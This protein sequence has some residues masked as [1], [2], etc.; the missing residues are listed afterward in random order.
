[1]SVW[2]KF[3]FSACLALG[4]LAV[5]EGVFRLAGYA[6]ALPL[7]SEKPGIQTYFWISDPRLGFR[8][9][10]NGDYVY[11]LI[12][13][14]PRVTTDCFGYRNGYGWFGPTTNPIV[15]FLGDSTVFCAEVDD[16]HTG[17]SE[18]A[19]LLGPGVSV[20]NAGVRG[21]STVQAKRMLEECLAR[22][23]SIKIVV[24]CFCGNDLEENLNSDLYFPARAPVL[25]WNEEKRRFV[26][27]EVTNPV[28]P[29]GN[30]FESWVAGHR[31][32]RRIVLQHKRWDRRFRDRLRERLAFFHALC[33]ATERL[34]DRRGA[35]QASESEVSEESNREAQP[36]EI[37]QVTALKQILTEM[38]GLCRRHDVAF[39]VTR[40]TRQ[41]N[42]AAIRRWCEEAG[43]RFVSASTYIPANDL[44]YRARTR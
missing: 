8:N 15:L 22:H 17:P 41:G 9:R 18:V 29:W 28:V 36:E 14:N 27:L 2:K 24:Y 34:R 11:D 32:A 33:L 21:Y 23:H 44:L 40:F 26:E 25:R 39:L 7:D 38:D 4:V 20:L 5:A 31:E 13:G 43:V 30:S 1:M 35:D 19:R 10:P 3:L 42:D 6:P 16:E 37:H 12:R